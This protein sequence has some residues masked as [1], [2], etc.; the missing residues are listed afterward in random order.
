M[1]EFSQAFT[2]LFQELLVALESQGYDHVAYRLRNTDLERPMSRFGSFSESTSRA[3]TV[4]AVYTGTAQRKRE[5]SPPFALSLR[6]VTVAASGPATFAASNV[7]LNVSYSS[8][9]SSTF[10]SQAGDFE[11]STTVI[12]SRIKRIEDAWFILSRRVT[13]VE[14]NCTKATEVPEEELQTVKDDLAYLKKETL[15]QVCFLR[16]LK[17]KFHF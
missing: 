15:Q 11:D 2:L 1:R 12:D 17:V 3:M 9:T 7:P 4:S 8:Q 13:R 16:P 6:D 10:D 5:A 14:D